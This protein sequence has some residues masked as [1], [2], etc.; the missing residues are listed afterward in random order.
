[1]I[2]FLGLAGGV[3]LRAVCPVPL[4]AAA[5]LREGAAATAHN[6]AC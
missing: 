1:M 5:D 6:L 3:T 4:P 2:F